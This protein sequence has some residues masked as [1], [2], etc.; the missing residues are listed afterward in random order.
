VVAAV[1]AHP[2]IGDFS[3][4]GAIIIITTTTT[5][6]SL[7]P[8][9]FLQAK[10]KEMLYSLLLLLFS[11]GGVKVEWSDPDFATFS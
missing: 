11:V 2:V 6:I 8:S 4:I 9:L 7:S 1:V 5:T 3:I 10:K